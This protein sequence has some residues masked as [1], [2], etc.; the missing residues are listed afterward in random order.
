MVALFGFVATHGRACV[1]IALRRSV[2]ISPFAPAGRLGCGRSGAACMAGTAAGLG[3]ACYAE[4]AMAVPGVTITCANC[5]A[6]RTPTLSEGLGALS[7]G[8]PIRCPCGGAMHVGKTGVRNRDFDGM[9]TG[10]VLKCKRCADT[11]P[12]AQ[13]DMFRYSK[14]S[15]LTCDKCGGDMC[16]A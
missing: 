11:R 5:K 13:A 1:A 6:Q 8:K 2:A 10:S 9:R 3:L 14:D 7:S 15:K 12:A 4:P 16:V